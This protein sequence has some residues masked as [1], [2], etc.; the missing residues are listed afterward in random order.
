M[1][2]LTNENKEEK[3]EFE[4]NE[5]VREKVVV[6]GLE[7]GFYILSENPYYYQDEDGYMIGLDN[8]FSEFKVINYENEIV[9]II[10]INWKEQCF[11]LIECVE[12]QSIPVQR[13]Q[14]IS[15]YTEL[16][17]L[18]ISFAILILVLRKFR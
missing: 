7:E 3:Y 16:I 6:Q 4:Y 5:C 11:D 8:T 10:N 9:Q 2:I 1:V 13:T 18:F 14:N 12:F 17:I 15:S